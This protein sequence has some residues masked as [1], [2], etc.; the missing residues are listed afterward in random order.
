MFNQLVKPS[1]ENENVHL[2]MTGYDFAAQLSPPHY[3]D[4]IEILYVYKGALLVSVNGS[5]IAIEA[6]S[7]MLLSPR[8]PHATRF[9]EGGGSYK[10]LQF[11]LENYLGDNINVGKY[12]NRFIQ[13]ASVPY[14][15]FESQAL[16]SVMNNIFLEYEEKKT[17]YILV[18]KGLV[19]NVVALLIREG[20]LPN[21]N[22]TY[23]EP[24]LKLLPSIAYIEEHYSEKITL[25]EIAA[26][27]RLAPSYFCRLFK[28]ASGTG[29][30]DYLNFVRIC[31]SERMLSHSEKSI[32]EISYE[33]GFSSVSYFNRLFKKYKNCTPSEY[34]AAQ[35]IN[36]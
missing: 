20:I 21:S 19:Y 9:A 18:I 2:G 35:S 36:R 3:H 28:K 34:R 4:E 11:R 5:E 12:F 22:I 8:I 17:E 31:K 14:T 13:S 25:N 15:V 1:F 30:V 27:Q 7:V 10:M 23:T 32:L 26:V 33:L 16:C 6:G 29:F 24:I